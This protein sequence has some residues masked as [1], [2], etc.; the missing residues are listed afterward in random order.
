MPSGRKFNMRAAQKNSRG[1]DASL[2]TT[3]CNCVLVCCLRTAHSRISARVIGWVTLVTEYSSLPSRSM[4]LRWMAAMLLM[5]S[6]I[7]VVH[8]SVSY[9]PSTQDWFFILNSAQACLAAQNKFSMQC[10]L[11]YCAHWTQSPAIG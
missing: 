1:A 10:N 8:C 3:A 5:L 11:A 4:S 6:C 9:E 2:P 7:V